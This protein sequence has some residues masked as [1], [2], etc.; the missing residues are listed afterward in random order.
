MNVNRNLTVVSAVASDNHLNNLAPFVK[1]VVV[2]KLLGDASASINAAQTKATLRISQGGANYETYLFYCLQCLRPITGLHE[3]KHK[4]RYDQRYSKWNA[5]GYFDTD[6]SSKL[7]SLVK[8]FYPESKRRLIGK[9]V[10]PDNI[11]DLL[12]PCAL[13][14]W[15]IDDGTRTGNLR[16]GLILCT[17]NFSFADVMK[18]YLVLERK[19]QLHVTLH[20]KP[21]GAYR[22]Y[23]KKNSI[24]QIGALTK[25]YVL[26]MYKYKITL[27]HHLLLRNIPF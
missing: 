20:T 10:V 8:D 24:N 7:I 17:D 25:P 9:K 19:F 18:L 16:G 13:A 14:F 1:D 6:S 3:I 26:D 22:I 11:W 12:T 4:S 21:R 2:G 27:F 23:I 15:I 5:L